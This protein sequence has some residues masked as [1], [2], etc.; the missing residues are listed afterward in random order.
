MRAVFYRPKEA[1]V[2][3]EHVCFVHKQ[4]TACCCCCYYL[5]AADCDERVALLKCCVFAMCHL[6]ATKALGDFRLISMSAHRSNQ[7]DR[8]ANNHATTQRARARATNQTTLVASK[9]RALP[10]PERHRQHA[11]CVSLTCCSK[12]RAR[13]LVSQARFCALAHNRL[14]RKSSGGGDVYT[15]AR[16]VGSKP[17]DCRRL[18]TRAV[19]RGDD[20]DDDGEIDSAAVG[21]ERAS[22]L[23]E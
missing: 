16:S 19:A 4:C 8:F 13:F 23:G 15:R 11:I 7:L 2:C 3:A 10:T 9:L 1:H 21:S 6:Q 17:I 12:A 5:I 22:S 20:N 18:Q 14:K